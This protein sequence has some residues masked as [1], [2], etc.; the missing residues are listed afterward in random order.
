MD[1]YYLYQAG[2]G[3]RPVGNPEG[4]ATS[5]EAMIA[6]DAN[7]GRAKCWVCR[8]NTP[9]QRIDWLKYNGW[10]ADGSPVTR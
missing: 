7:N 5:Q 8:G 6:L 3:M 4:Y 10:N 9:Q 2:Q 1:T